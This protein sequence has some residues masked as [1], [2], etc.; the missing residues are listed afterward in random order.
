[1]SHGPPYRFF[2]DYSEGA[3]PVILRHVADNNGGQQPGYGLD[4][5][6][7]LAA[8]R[9]RARFATDGD[10]HFV[11]GSTQANLIGLSSM[12]APY[13]GVVAPV[14]GHIAVHEA[15]A[16]E[17]TGHKIIAIDAADSDGRLTPSLLDAALRTHEDEHTVMPKAVF[18]TQATELGTV[19]SKDEFTAVV[20]HAK[21]CDLYV[22]VDGARL[23]T[24]L[25]SERAGMDF[26]D[27][28]RAGVDMFTVGGTKAGGMFGEAIVIVNAELKNNFRYHLKQRGALLAKGRFMGLQFERFFDN[29]DL[30]LRMGSLANENATYLAM[31]FESCG[32]ELATPC[33]TNQVFVVLDDTII[34]QLRETYGF[35]NWAPAGDGRSVVRL[36]CSWATQREAID[37]LATDLAAL[38]RSS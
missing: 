23:A 14:T 7:L 30:W 34:E 22:F 3:H 35:Y 20:R 37:R 24:A 25:A 16:I 27:L 28:V 32:V 19:Y 29:D 31:A 8:D 11:S 15:G 10:V 36:V 9:I 33:D 6:C 18:L 38:T 13:Q 26:S 1:M 5:A 21:E 4:D 12:L 17:A 2:D